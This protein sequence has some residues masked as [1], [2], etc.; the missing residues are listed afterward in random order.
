MTYT[1]PGVYIE[2]L[3]SGTHT[4]AA[5]STSNTAF[6]DYFARGPVDRA[7]QITSLADFNRIYGGLDQHSEASYAILQ[8]FLNGGQ[9]AAVGRVVIGAVPAGFTLVDADGADSLKVDS[10]NPG[11]WGN[12]LY[13]GVTPPSPSSRAA[14]SS[15]EAQPFDLAVQEI[16]DGRVVNS[17]M[18]YGLTMTPGQ[19]SFAPDV[20]NNQ[21]A[22][23]RLKDPGTKPPKP[24]QLDA[25]K[26]AGGT[27]GA[28]PPTPTEN[29]TWQVAIDDGL[30][31]LKPVDFQ[32]LCLPLIA[33]LDTD[34]QKI[35]IES[36]QQ[37]CYTRRAFFIIDAPKGAA[38]A[39]TENLIQNWLPAVLPGGTYY[40]Y[41]AL[42]FPRLTIPD[43]INQNRPRDVG[44]SGA[45]AGVYARTD[46]NRGVWKAP[47]G[48]D[49]VLN[50]ASLVSK[51]TDA[52]NQ[53]LNPIGVNA[54][55][56]FPIYGN[57]V[58]GAR[59]LDGS[60]QKNSDYKY[61]P[62]RRLTSFIEESLYQGTKWAVF[63]PNDA[64]LWSS[65]RLSVDTF[66][67]WLSS[68][69]AFYRYYVVC[70]G[71]T[72]TARDIATGVCNIVVAFAPVKPAEFIVLQVQQLAGQATV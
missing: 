10:A 5:V 15:S 31:L 7:V 45:V 50:G 18:Y 35:M 2:E 55:R 26:L 32:I 56:N 39:T 3:P 60:D 33:L 11:T 1:Y 44:P 25:T 53:F 64:T 19:P 40:A 34:S 61:V 52:D 48:T 57:I 20:V 69:G 38:Y 68:Q 63:E 24:Y 54:L 49:A 37:F 16:V 42:Y 13:L 46:A 41:S 12:N 62:V 17:E 14:E 6:V 47:A 72:T 67:A 22:L 43:P 4:I 29:K 30:G 59:T 21:S 9:V 66:M 71:T 27:T 23:I 28:L 70:D 8:Y 65:L 36:A 51:I 58:W